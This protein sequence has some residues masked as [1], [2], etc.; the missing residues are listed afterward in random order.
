MIK[1]LKVSGSLSLDSLLQRPT[2]VFWP[3]SELSFPDTLRHNK[4]YLY[5]YI[6]I[7]FYVALI[8]W[9]LLNT[10]YTH[11]HHWYLIVPSSN[12]TI[13]LICSYYQDWNQLPISIINWPRCEFPWILVLFVCV[14]LYALS[15]IY[16]QTWPFVSLVHQ[17]TD[18][19]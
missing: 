9:I 17:W 18:S 14:L 1:L 6:T 8:I 7:N 11:H 5:G 3:P 19:H 10:L 15:I 13:S 12:T 2:S 4:S 16:G